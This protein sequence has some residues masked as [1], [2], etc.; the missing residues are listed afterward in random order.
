MIEK[1]YYKK[2]NVFSAQISIINDYYLKYRI[3]EKRNTVS[4]CRNIINSYNGQIA[5]F[6]KEQCHSTIQ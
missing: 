2:L 3:R 4:D 1:M 5:T 6:G